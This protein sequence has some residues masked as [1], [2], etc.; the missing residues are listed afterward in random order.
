M[1]RLQEGLTR[2]RVLVRIK[3][4]TSPFLVLY[5]DP[6]AC[7]EHCI[8]DVLAPSFDSRKTMF[9]VDTF[10]IA[11]SHLSGGASWALRC[12]AGLFGVSCFFN[13]SSQEHLS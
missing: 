1:N 4:C 3:R 8:F 9:L 2:F 13:L 7:E 11:P 10:V 12:S 5:L 6:T